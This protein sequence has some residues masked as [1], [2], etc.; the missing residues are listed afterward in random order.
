MVDDQSM[1]EREMVTITIEPAA[2]RKFEVVAPIDTTHTYRPSF[3]G[4]PRP[5]DWIDAALEDGR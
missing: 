2:G 3:E 4:G 1:I 5:S